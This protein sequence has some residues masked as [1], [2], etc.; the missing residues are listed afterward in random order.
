MFAVKPSKWLL[1]VYVFSWS[2][3]SSGFGTNTFY[4][5]LLLGSD[6]ISGSAIA[7]N[8]K[9]N[10]RSEKY[11]SS[12]KLVN[13]YFHFLW[14][15]KLKFS[16]AFVSCNSSQHRWFKVYFPSAGKKNGFLM[17]KSCKCRIENLIPSL[18]EWI[19]KKDARRWFQTL[20]FH[21]CHPSGIGFFSSNIWTVLS[22]RKLNFFLL[23]KEV[24]CCSVELEPTFVS[25][26]CC[27]WLVR[28]NICT[29]CDTQ[30]DSVICIVPIAIVPSA[31]IKWQ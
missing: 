13:Q 28:I 5:F 30:K 20:N 2:N 18:I 4:G 3:S 11:V 1:A 12:W 7:S 8:Y 6:S 22:A 31:F 15:N 10:W 27:R 21:F 26:K 9:L 23:L 25:W 17:E 14:T 16:S 19:R 24:S 29:K